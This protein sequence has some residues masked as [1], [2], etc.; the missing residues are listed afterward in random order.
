MKFL[1]AIWKWLDGNKTL[2]G[3][4]LIVLLQGGM[5]GEAGVLFDVITWLSGILTAGGVLHKIAK[6]TSN[7]GK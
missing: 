3:T 1:T 4:L 7:T 5:F 6:G 2:I